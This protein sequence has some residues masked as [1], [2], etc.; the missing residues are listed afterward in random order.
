MRPVVIAWLAA[1]GLPGWLSPD[2]VT[3]VG[4]CSLLGAWLVLRLAAQDGARVHI[5]ARALLIA[6]G[7]AMLGGYVFEWIRAIPEALAHRSLAPLL[8][9]GRAAYGGLIFGFLAPV[10]WLRW[11]KE[12]VAPFLDRATIP[13][14]IA[15]GAVRVGCF[16]EGCDFGRPTAS[17][18]GV[19]FPAG[20][21]AAEAHLHAGWIPAGAPSL[22]VHPTELYESAL[23]LVAMLLALIPIRRGF[24][25][26]TAFAVWVTTYASGRFLIELLR[27]DVDRGVYGALSTA[28]WVSV[29]L[30][31]G[32]A[33]SIHPVVRRRAGTFAT[34]AVLIARI[35]AVP[36]IV[37][38]APPTPLPPPLPPTTSAPAP[39]PP[40][41]P[42]GT[43]SQ[44][45]P[46]P[47][48]PPPSTT[49]PPPN[50]PPSAVPS[51]QSV[52]V[53]SD[54]DALAAAEKRHADA[55]SRA[56]A[57]RADRDF[58]I[59]AA[60]VGSAT[61]GRPD[62]PSGAAGELD[63]LARLRIGGHARIDLGLEGR[64]YSNSVA[65]HHSLGVVGELAIELGRR[66]DV[67]FTLVP[68]HTWFDFKSDFFSNT[69]AYG[70][71]YGAGLQLTLRDRVL[72]GATPL[73]FTST[74]SET[75]GV[76]TQWEPR[77]WGGVLF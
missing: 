60:L 18:L 77:L 29:I 40:P 38:A 57:P 50:M 66:F 52:V 25:N 30:L 55:V 1:H 63:L 51:A 20:S 49:Q 76:L 17:W 67:T 64:E 5:Q 45:P 11:R 46:T 22:P 43:P 54:A 13:T 61:L 33:L 27:G 9:A 14:G 32:V 16:L 62:V 74:S 34:A 39:L 58:A 59:R 37:Q 3:T 2:Y 65:R 6:Y 70:V 12:P 10:L 53:V 15:Y 36:R 48:A 4:V 44:P 26:G 28:Q 68:H 71:R 19:R 24:R 41:S 7:A 73:A 56:S 47:P 8:F 72:L 35:V 21:L 23:G 31:A 42:P 75:V 69:N